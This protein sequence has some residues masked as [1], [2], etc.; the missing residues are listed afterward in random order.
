MLK[1]ILHLL[2]VLAV[3]LILFPVLQASAQQLDKQITAAIDQNG[4][5]G[6]DYTSSGNSSRSTY[7]LVKCERIVYSWKVR[8]Y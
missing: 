4:G 6:D 1:F 7:K 5:T 8:R 3:L 2:L